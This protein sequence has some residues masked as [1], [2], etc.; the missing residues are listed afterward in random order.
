MSAKRCMPH[1]ALMTDKINHISESIHMFHTTHLSRRVY[2]LF[3]YLYLQHTLIDSGGQRK[4]KIYAK[5]WRSL[6]IERWGEKFLT[7]S[8]KWHLLV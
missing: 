5:F 8:K 1:L 6:F 3:I 2:T 4:S 7:Q